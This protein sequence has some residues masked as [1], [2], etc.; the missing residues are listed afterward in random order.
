MTSRKQ[1]ILIENKSEISRF[2]DRKVFDEKIKSIVIKDAHL[3]EVASKEGKFI[4]S[5]D[6]AARDK[7]SSIECIRHTVRGILWANPVEDSEA[8]QMKLEKMIKYDTIKRLA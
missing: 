5:R 8:L 2:I 6:N 7:I 3:L 1:V 4:V